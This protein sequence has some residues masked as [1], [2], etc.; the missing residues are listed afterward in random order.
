MKNNSP[1]KPFIMTFIV[2]MVRCCTM[3]TTY[4]TMSI[5]CLFHFAEVN[6]LTMPQILMVSK[7]SLCNFPPN[8]ADMTIL[9]DQTVNCFLSNRSFAVAIEIDI[10]SRL[11]FYSDFEKKTI[12]RVRLLDGEAVDTIRGGVGSVEGE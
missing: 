7:T 1:C 11:L 8:F 12:E 10:P 5:Q 9:P 3:S 6:G 2:L 4:H